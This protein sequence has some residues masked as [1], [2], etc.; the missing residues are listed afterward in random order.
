M[1]SSSDLDFEDAE[2]VSNKK[3]RNNKT[4]TGKLLSPNDPFSRNH[5][6]SIQLA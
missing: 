2:E 3:K 6:V 5:N 4:L 1:P